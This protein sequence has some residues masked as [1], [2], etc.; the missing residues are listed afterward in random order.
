MHCSFFSD[1][2]MDSSEY[3]GDEYSVMDKTVV[4][5]EILGNVLRGFLYTLKDEDIFITIENCFSND[6]VYEARKIL[7]RYFFEIFENEEP[8]GRY[9]G[10]KE[11]EIKK[12]ENIFDIIEKMHEITKLDHEVEFCIP[13]N[14]SYLVV[15]DEEKRFREMV[16]Q[17]DLEID[18]KFQ[19]LEEV[20]DKK[21]REMITA[22]KSIIQQV[23]NIEAEGEMY[24]HS[25][26]P[27]DT[28]DV[29][30]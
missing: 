7:V 27:E 25:S 15:S 3:S 2:Q 19:C 23:G 14:Y 24:I 17:K 8:N 30:G 4:N 16:R 21:N 10:P 1:Y 22:V 11:R 5:N 12:D 18:N 28:A 26:D 9:M 20:I 29:K 6:E 13:W